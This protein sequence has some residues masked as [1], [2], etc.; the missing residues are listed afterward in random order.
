ML[1]SADTTQTRLHCC[2]SPADAPVSVDILT[3][4][5]CWA[6][7]SLV[8]LHLCS[9]RKCV[10]MWHV[11]EAADNGR[12]MVSAAMAARPRANCDT[13]VTTVSY[14][15]T[16]F[17]TGSYSTGEEGAS[18]RRGVPLS[19]PR[20]ASRTTQLCVEYTRGASTRSEMLRGV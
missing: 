13:A 11:F 4:L 8:L 3:V 9:S 7:C 1:C 14:T 10:N 16:V 5:Q 19:Q 2:I 17:S 18:P 12:D 6:T 15:R 20:V